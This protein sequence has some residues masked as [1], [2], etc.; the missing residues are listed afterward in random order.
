MWL[1]IHLDRDRE[2]TG[3]LSPLCTECPHG[4]TGCCASPPG[5]DWSDVGRVLTLGGRHWLSA[6]MAAGR[7]TSMQ[8]RHG[9]PSRGL[10]LQRVDNTAIN[11]ATWPTKCV[12]HGERGCTIERTQRPA[13]CNYYLCDDAYDR[14]GPAGAP[15]RAAHT[16]LQTLYGRWDLEIAEA[17]HSAWPHEIPWDTD[18]EAVFDLIEQAYRR[19]TARD[20]AELDGLCR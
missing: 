1:P 9:V 7:V 20:Q 3:L 19:L 15:A 14:A 17:V 4:P 2:H 10:Q 16:T 11:T 18:A 13:T 12:Y 5:F 8:H 6:Q